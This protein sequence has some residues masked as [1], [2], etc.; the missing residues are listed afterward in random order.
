MEGAHQTQ[1]EDD[2]ALL[3]EARRLYRALLDG[4]RGIFWRAR[5]SRAYGLIEW[6]EANAARIDAVLARAQRRAEVEAWPADDAMSSCVAELARVRERLIHLCA[7]KAGRDL[8]D[9]ASALAGLKTALLSR[10][11]AVRS[12]WAELRGL[13]PQSDAAVQRVGALGAFLEELFGKPLPLRLDEKQLR[14]LEREWSFAERDYLELWGRIAAAD[15]SGK[16]LRWAQRRS[17][18]A[19]VRRPKD[20]A[21]ALMHAT[22]WAAFFEWR[23]VDRGEYARALDATR[24]RPPLESGALAVVRARGAG[25]RG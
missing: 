23:P 6:C 14:Q 1:L 25:A 24:K 2:A 12:P 18:L 16:L 10:R 22:F 5:L 7:R 13:L 20:G 17:R 4:G 8:P 3:F 19:P 15:P 9:V 11:G 21:E